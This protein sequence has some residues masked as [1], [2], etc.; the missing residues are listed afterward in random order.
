MVPNSSGERSTSRAVGSIFFIERSE[1]TDIFRIIFRDVVLD[2]H[3]RCDRKISTRSRE[4]WDETESRYSQ[5]GLSTVEFGNDVGSP[6]GFSDDH[7][8]SKIPRF[9]LAAESI[10][11]TR[12]PNEN[13]GSWLEVE[14]GDTRRMD[15][16]KP[17]EVLSS[18][19]A[20]D[21]LHALTCLDSL[22]A[23]IGILLDIGPRHPSAKQFFSKSGKVD[24]SVKKCQN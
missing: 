18:G 15:S 3:V 12:V 8:W 4:V 19:L 7:H 2:G 16:L 11:D 5:F 13:Q 9:C 10:F 24:Q 1:E 20:H 14:V 22:D 21:H 6:D 23:A 17:L